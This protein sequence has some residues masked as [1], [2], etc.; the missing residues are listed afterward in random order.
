MFMVND[1]HNFLLTHDKFVKLS[2]D[3]DYQVP[4]NMDFSSTMFVLLSLLKKKSIW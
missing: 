3:I 4:N 1:R 2:M